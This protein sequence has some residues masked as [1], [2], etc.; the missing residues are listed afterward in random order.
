MVLP[1]IHV[2]PRNPA[3]FLAMDARTVAEIARVKMGTLNQWIARGLIAGME[4]RTSGKRRDFDLITAIRIAIFAEMMRL[5]VPPDLAAIA[6]AGPVKLDGWL[7]FFPQQPLPP[8]VAARLDVFYEATHEDILA[9]LASQPE[10]PI[11][12]AVI[13]VA[14]LVERAGQLA[15]AVRDEPEAA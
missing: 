12:Y 3:Y 1:Q 7:L 2:K 13:S 8:G 4:V 10:P 15:A 11:S 5:G 9:Q 14:Q 6:I